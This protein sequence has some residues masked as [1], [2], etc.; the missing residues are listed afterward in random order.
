MAHRRRLGRP[1]G[2]IT[3]M[4]KSRRVGFARYQPTEDAVFELFAR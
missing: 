3:D 4:S 1:G 2:P